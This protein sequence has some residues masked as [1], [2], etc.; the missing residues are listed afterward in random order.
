MPVSAY[1]EKRS[2]K[3]RSRSGEGSKREGVTGVP[4]WLSLKGE[5]NMA[6]RG[7]DDGWAA[8]F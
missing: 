1:D 3:V 6:T 4:D 8:C 2:H 7:G 5:G